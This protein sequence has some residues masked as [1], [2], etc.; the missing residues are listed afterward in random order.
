MSLPDSIHTGGFHFCR[1]MEM[2]ISRRRGCKPM[3]REIGI[4][5]YKTGIRLIKSYCFPALLK[6]AITHHMVAKNCMIM[7][8]AIISHRS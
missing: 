1:N 2:P 6:R 4:S 8:I 7:L 5:S 3:Y